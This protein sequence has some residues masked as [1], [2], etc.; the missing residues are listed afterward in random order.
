MIYRVGTWLMY[1]TTTL[2]RV[3]LVVVVPYRSHVPCLTYG[4]IGR[5]NSQGEKAQRQK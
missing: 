1:G 5:G 4:D 2:H 3:S